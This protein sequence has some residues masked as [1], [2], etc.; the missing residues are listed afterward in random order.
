MD[1]MEW[2]AVAAEADVPARGGLAVLARGRAVA[3]FRVGEA[4]HAIEDRCPHQ[5]APLSE[6]TLAGAVVTC[7]LH[8]WQ[9]DVTTGRAP[10]GEFPRVARFPVRVEGGCVYVGVSD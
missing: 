1:G 9:I 6:G 5:Y 3:L 4:I 10:I 2:I 8:A 7:A